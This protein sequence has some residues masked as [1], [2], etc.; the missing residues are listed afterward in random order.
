MAQLDTS[1]FKEFFKGVRGRVVV[2]A[3]AVLL[4]NIILS[5]YVVSPLTETEGALKAHVERI[6]PG[7]AEGVGGARKAYDD[8]STF[9]ERLSSKEELTATLSKVFKAAKRQGLTI[10]Q[11][12]YSP[13]KP[14]AFGVSRYTVSFPVS[15]VY[16]KIKKFIH[17]LESMKTP[18]AV[19]ELALSRGTKGNLIELNV[20][21]SAYFIG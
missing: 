8:I 3:L 20:T 12:N 16:G 19:E 15:G 7:T 14:D 1:L 2:V 4:L 18:L 17:A 6:E 13:G 9:R 11:S 21:L 5:I 10:K